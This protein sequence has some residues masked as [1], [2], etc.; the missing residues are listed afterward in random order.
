M[1]QDLNYAEIIIAGKMKMNK[2]R[3]MIYQS[4]TLAFF[5]ILNLVA[6]FGIISTTI[7]TAILVI[8]YPYNG[9]KSTIV[10]LIL[11]A[12]LVSIHFINLPIASLGFHYFPLQIF[13]LV[14]LG[15]VIACFMA[16]TTMY[17]VS[18][19]IDIRKF[20]KNFS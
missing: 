7:W 12:G 15:C 19:I 4:L 10:F 1:R 8:M 11:E 14:F 18:E 9:F 13:S 16:F 20:L 2:T 5:A 17:C 6:V 3:Q